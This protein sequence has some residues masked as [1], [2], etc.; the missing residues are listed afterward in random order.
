MRNTSLMDYVLSTSFR[1]PASW[2]P[3]KVLDAFN[4]CEKTFGEERPGNIVNEAQ[5]GQLD[6][7]DGDW[8]GI[9]CDFPGTDWIFWFSTQD[10][11]T[12]FTLSW[13]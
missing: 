4:W 9:W 1:V 2:S 3:A 11:L 7:F 13:N 8:C 5:E 12:Q 10:R 6:Y